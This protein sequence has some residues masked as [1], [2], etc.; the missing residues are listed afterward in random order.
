MSYTPGKWIIKYQFNVYNEKGRHIAACGGHSSNIDAEKVYAE[1]VSNAQLISAAPE[2]FE[3]CK[4]ILHALEN[5][6]G[7]FN[8]S[9]SI[10]DNL[11]NAI[12][13]AEGK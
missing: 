13:K 12:K 3:A 9:P 2:L 10:E 7:E 1:N 4:N 6:P 5:C 8:Y 11:R